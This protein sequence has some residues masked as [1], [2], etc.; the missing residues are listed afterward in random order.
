MGSRER[1]RSKPAAAESVLHLH[2]HADLPIPLGMTGTTVDSSSESIP[3]R[4]TFYESGFVGVLRRCP[5]LDYSC[6]AGGGAFLST[7]SDLVRFG[8]AM[9]GGKLLQPLRSPS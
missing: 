8:L 9:N 3:D 7:P 2:A 1:R 6:F 4:T 5:G